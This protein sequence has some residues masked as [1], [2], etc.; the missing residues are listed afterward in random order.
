MPTHFAGYELFM[1]AWE[2]T[3]K[4]NLR[5][6]YCYKNSKEFN[7]NTDNFEI[8]K[9]VVKEIS[10]IPSIRVISVTGGEP[11]LSPYF[12]YVIKKLYKLKRYIVITTNGMIK[13]RKR[14]AE[15][16][17]KYRKKLRIQ[18]SIE[19]KKETHEFFR[20]K[21]TF[22][23]TITTAK[24]F[25][26]NNIPISFMITAFKSNIKQLEYVLNLQKGI[27]ADFVAIERFIPTG[28]GSSLKKE[29]ISKK[30][31]ILLLRKVKQLQKKGEKIYLND[32][33]CSI[34]TRGVGCSAGISSLAIT[35]TGL[36]LPCS[37]LR[38][39]VGDIKKEKLLDIWKNSTLL[40]KLRNRRN[41]KG[42]CQSCIYRNHCGGCRALTYS[43]TGNIF[44]ED[45]LCPLT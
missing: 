13:Q 33:L 41:L 12:E 36:V 29:L 14:I 24:L 38:I 9:K 40:K 28:I 45:P 43:I 42:K 8:I 1:I 30:D 34:N 20:G 11:T 27:G 7:I 26:K 37:K 22:N 21:N 35:S 4:C 23:E 19:G 39:P 16:L 10:T 5:C 18:I 17:K 6:I 2:I 44:A 15:I 32:P 25:S 31:F 3:D